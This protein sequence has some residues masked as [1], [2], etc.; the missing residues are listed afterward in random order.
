MA[1]VVKEDPEASTTNKSPDTSSNIEA[2][3]AF[4]HAQAYSTQSQYP[5]L[6]TSFGQNNAT[7]LQ[8]TPALQ[9]DSLAA[10]PPRP[11][12]ASLP[13]QLGQSNDHR[14]SMDSAA[15][16]PQS[17]AADA[18]STGPVSKVVHIPPRPKPGRKPMPP[19]E[20]S[21]RRRTQNRMA[22]RNFRDKRQQRV[23]ELNEELTQLQAKW[24][25]TLKD[26]ERLR[27]QNAEER[28][29]LIDGARQREDSL[30]AELSSVKHRLAVY[31]QGAASQVQTH[32]DTQGR[33]SE[34]YP[35]PNLSWN[36][37]TEFQYN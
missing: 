4:A 18:T 13:T 7:F 17:P 22:Q 27:Q 34:T 8:A 6:A 35:Y 10:L 37:E 5:A 32:P 24:Q 28:Q 25:Q 11:S 26:F 29:I 16:G 21:D 31:E 9:S 12:Q 23:F 1:I 3:Q 14:V 15:N 2:Q 33:V 19:G 36:Q 30:L 20:A